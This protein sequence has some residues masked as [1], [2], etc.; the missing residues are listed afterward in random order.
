MSNDEGALSAEHRLALHT[1]RPILEAVGAPE[2]D[3]RQMA[4]TN[5]SI[6]EFSTYDGLTRAI[7]DAKR[8]PLGR[9]RRPREWL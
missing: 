2:P 4:I 5:K 3:M 7:L 6:A 8:G 1:L 9:L